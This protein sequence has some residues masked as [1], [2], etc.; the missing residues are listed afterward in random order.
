MS[1]ATQSNHKR[2]SFIGRCLV[3][4]VGIA[5]LAASY[6]GYAAGRAIGGYYFQNPGSVVPSVELL[7][8]AGVAVYFLLVGA[9]GRWVLLRRLRKSR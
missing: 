7:A 8:L 3:A 9:T 6:V 4:I 1:A 5:L 2:I